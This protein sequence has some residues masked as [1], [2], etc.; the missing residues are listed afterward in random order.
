MF[1]LALTRGGDAGLYCGREGLFLGPGPLI[2]RVGDEY[3]LRAQDEIVM[4]LAAAYEP[5]EATAGLLP[6]L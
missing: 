3:R 4:L 2:E 1:K 5:D 6:R